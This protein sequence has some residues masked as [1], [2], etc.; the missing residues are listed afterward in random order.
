MHNY[1]LCKP[2]NIARND[3]FDLKFLNLHEIPVPVVLQ[4][5]CVSIHAVN[6]NEDWPIADFTQ[7]K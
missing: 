2:C 5:S 7:G 4:V 6:M 3:G 1:K